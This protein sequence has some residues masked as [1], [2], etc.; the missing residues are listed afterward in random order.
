LSAYLAAGISTDHECSAPAE[1]LEKLEKGVFILIREGSAA[2]NLEALV[3]VV[4]QYNSRFFGFC[5][6]DR[7]PDFLVEHGHINQMVK[8]AITLG[9][10][11]VI[12]LQMAS[13]NTARYYGLKNT[14]TLSIG[15]QA[16]LVVFDSFERFNITKV[17][18]AGELV[19]KDGELLREPKIMK[20][21]SENSVNIPTLP[22]DFFTVKNQ[23]SPVKVMELVPN[24][25]ITRQLI[26]HFQTETKE[27][28]AQPEQDI[29][30]VA[31]IERHR[32]CGNGMTGFVRGF[33]LKTG[34]IASTVAHDSHNLIILGTNDDDMLKAV[35][36][37]RRIKGGLVVVSDGKLVASLPLPLAGI[38]SE[39]SLWEVKEQYDILLEETAKLGCKI[40]D[41]FMMLSFLALPVIGDLK[42]TDQGLVD[43]KKFDFVSLYGDD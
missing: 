29:L 28:K 2:K 5:T 43:V 39:Q 38:M 30:K 20:D 16:D 3:P 8:K 19:V 31:V 7:H 13:V 33:G 32:G 36:F 42:I 14:G 35:D 23:N 24:Q 15:S 21:S 25:I 10:D 41:P 34:A 1:A 22:V 4:N 11:P 12:A 18:K 40:A 6:D 9:V 26:H 27:L 17:F 37:I